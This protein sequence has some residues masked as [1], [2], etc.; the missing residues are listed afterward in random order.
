MARKGIADIFA[1]PGH[2]EFYLELASNPKLR[3]LVHISRVDIGSTC[4]AANLGIVFDGCYYHV[5]ASYVDSEV[6]HYGPGA[7]H[8]RELMAHAISLGLQRFDFTIGDEPY[9]LDWSDTVL[10]LYDYSATKT[11][12]GLPARWV[13]SVRRRVKRLIK[14][15]PAL[16]TL[17]S[18]ARAAVGSLSRSSR[19]E[20]G[21]VTVA[22]APAV[23]KASACVMGD[24]DL[25]GRWR[26]PTFPVLS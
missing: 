11:W 9:K 6:A 24:M 14:Q 16:W 20:E 1:P 26:W 15:T 19:S 22:A 7:L 23:G 5:L 12:R 8:L 13:S 21:Q 2:R 4:A 25:C 3:H 17:A 10:K 18:R